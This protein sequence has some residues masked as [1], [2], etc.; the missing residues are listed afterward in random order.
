[1]LFLL[2]AGIFRS[3]NVGVF[4]LIPVG[5][6]LSMVCCFGVKVVIFRNLTPTLDCNILFLHKNG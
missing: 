2:R 1:M 4:E 5:K 6:K 3:W